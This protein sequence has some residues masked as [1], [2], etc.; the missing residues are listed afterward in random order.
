MEDAAISQ[1]MKTATSDESKFRVIHLIA[2]RAVQIQGGAK[3]LIQT[4]ARK[5]TRIA[6][7]EFEA[8]AIRYELLPV[9]AA[10]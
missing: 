5:A 2:R 6:R 10:Q 1:I 3:P 7:D 8:G 9:A 4:I